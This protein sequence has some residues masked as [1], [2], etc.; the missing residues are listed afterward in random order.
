MRWFVPSFRDSFQ[1]D[2]AAVAIGASLLPTI[3]A[4][5]KAVGAIAPPQGGRSNPTGPVKDALAGRILP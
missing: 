5:P 1:R 4:G 3:A 2:V